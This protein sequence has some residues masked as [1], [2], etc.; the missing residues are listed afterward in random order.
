M[1]TLEEARRLADDFEAVYPESLPDRLAWWATVLEIPRRRM[2]LL[3][4]IRGIDLLRSSRRS[5]SWSELI[6]SR[7]DRASWI[8]DLLLQLLSRHSYDTKALLAS[9]R[10]RSGKRRVASGLRRTSMTSK[11]RRPRHTSL[12]IHA[13]KERKIE[14]IRDSELIKRVWLGGPQALTALRD[15][16]SER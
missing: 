5:R 16:L 4:G 12:S 1:P 13:L 10:V 8:N 6:E 15:F 7:S 9:L 11:P 3:L 2:L 14:L